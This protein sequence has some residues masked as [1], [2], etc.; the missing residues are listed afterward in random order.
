MKVWCV[1]IRHDWNNR[2]LEK[3]FVNELY[4]RKYRESFPEHCQ[5]EHEIEEWEVEGFRK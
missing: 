5:W 4:A 2:D 3:V 1:F